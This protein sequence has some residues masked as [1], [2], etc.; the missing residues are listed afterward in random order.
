M[1]I[2]NTH[3]NAMCASCARFGKDCEGT[4]CQTWT[5]CAMKKAA[6]PDKVICKPRLIFNEQDKGTDHAYNVQLWHSY[7]GGKNFYYAGYGRYFGDYYEAEAWRKAHS[8]PLPRDLAH[9]DL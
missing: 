4:T 2:E 8:V 9:S 1:K 7:D 5:G 6:D 3:V